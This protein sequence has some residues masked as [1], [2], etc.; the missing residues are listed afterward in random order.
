MVMVL[1]CL[2]V[3]AIML[4]AIAIYAKSISLISSLAIIGAVIG[5]G[6]FLLLI[7][8]MG[9]IGAVKHHQICL[10]FVSFTCH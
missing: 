9:F 6:V 3:I 4:T 2:Q 5:C 7:A 8:C 1:F 10:F